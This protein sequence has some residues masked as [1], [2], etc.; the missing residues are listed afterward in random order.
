[1]FESPSSE[2]KSEIVRDA[3]RD[4][5]GR[6]IIPPRSPG[7]PTGKKALTFLKEALQLEAKAKGYL[8]EDG[9]AQHFAKLAFTDIQVARDVGRALYLPQSK[10]PMSRRSL[11][12]ILGYRRQY[13][14][15]AVQH[16]EREHQ[17]AQFP[18]MTEPA[19][20]ITTYDV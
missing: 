19:P 12:L 7:H 16:A 14:E 20:K 5:R 17:L 10:D 6:F 4:E 2:A 13:Q 18:P 11:I 9:F 15:A 8:G 3:V 1:M